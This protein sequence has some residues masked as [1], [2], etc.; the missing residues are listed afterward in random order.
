MSEINMPICGEIR[1]PFGKFYLFCFRIS[2]AKNQP[3]KTWLKVIWGIDVFFWNVP[4]L[5][6]FT[7]INIVI[8]IIL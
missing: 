7:L 1:E 3:L 4:L 6:L 8:S 5:K 2:I